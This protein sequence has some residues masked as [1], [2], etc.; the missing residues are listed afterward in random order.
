LLSGPAK[1]RSIGEQFSI[2]FISSS[3]RV[4]KLTLFF[5]GAGLAGQIRP[6]AI[7]AFYEAAYYIRYTK[8]RKEERTGKGRRRFERTGKK[9]ESHELAAN[10]G[11]G[12]TS[13][14]AGE[15]GSTIASAFAACLEL[16]RNTSLKRSAKPALKTTLWLGFLR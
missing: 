10:A 3:L 16:R 15:K 8:R 2:L 14:G 5:P 4:R 6:R 13:R 1:V 12:A 7:Q 9:K 11:S